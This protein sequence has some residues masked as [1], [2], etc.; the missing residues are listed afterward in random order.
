MKKSPKSIFKIFF[1]GIYNGWCLFWFVFI[2]LLLYPFTYIFLQNKRWHR[3]VHT[4]NRIWAFL[5]F[6]IIGKPLKISYEFE[7]DNSKTYVFVANHFSYLDVAV[8]MGVVKNYFA[9]VGK[10]S[11]S[12]VP[13]FGYMF[14]KH[15]IMVDRER[16]ES[17]SRSLVR[18]LKTLQEGRSIF[19][20]PEGGIVSKH[21]PKMHQ[22]FKEGA[23]LMAIENQVPIVPITFLNLYN[24]MPENR[25]LWGVPRIIIH[26]PI[27]TIGKT[28]ENIE[29]LK[30]AVYEVIQGAID[31]YQK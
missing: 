23:F 8:G 13:M 22:P 6:P 4:I 11:V 19:I 16:K 5:Y 15:H 20:M 17:R 7:P 31:A 2:F 24:I 18:G 21:I 10:S 3:Y 9:Y 29:E 27:E 25:L 1:L 30:Q 28:K 14:K 12:K 26:Q